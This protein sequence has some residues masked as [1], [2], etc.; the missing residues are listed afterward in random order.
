MNVISNHP[1]TQNAKETLTNGTQ[2]SSDH[3]EEALAADHRPG[4]VAESVKIQSTKTKNE[5][6]GLATSRVQPDHTAANGQSLTRT[7]LTHLSF[8]LSHR[9]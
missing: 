3:L 7:A 8:A 2:Q 6:A 9:L 4:P 1:V 5:F